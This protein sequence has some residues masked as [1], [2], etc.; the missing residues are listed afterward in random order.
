LLTQERKFVEVAALKYGVIINDIEE[1]ATSSA[2][3]RIRK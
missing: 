3:P 1:T 2:S